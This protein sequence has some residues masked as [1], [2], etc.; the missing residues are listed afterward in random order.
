MAYA[1]AYIVRIEYGIRMVKDDQGLSAGISRLWQA[2]GERPAREALT[3]TRIVQAA[4]E[5]ADTEGLD[6][7]SMA[8]V[9]ERLGAGTMSL[10]RHV[11]GKDELLILM[12][13]SVW[14]QQEDP[15][16]ADLSAGWRPALEEWCRRQH[17]TYARH[18]WL[19][20]VRFVERAGTPSQLVTLDRGLAILAGTLLSEADKVAALMLLNGYLLWTARYD[21]ELRTAATALHLPVAQVAGQFGELMRSLTAGEDFPALARAVAG[22]AFTSGGPAVGDFEWGLALILDALV[23]RTPA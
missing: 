21:E 22:G 14:R 17:E 6:A 5:L 11:A 20:R 4:V 15:A 18:P 13:D 7:V 2:R 12:H 10:Y 16:P 23:T 8:H 3:A 1:R 19:E 9:A